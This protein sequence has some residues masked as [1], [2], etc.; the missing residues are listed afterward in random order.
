MKENKRVLITIVILL[1]IFLP[2]T[3]I[4]IVNNQSAREKDNDNENN[5]RELYKNGYLWFYD[6]KGMF[7][8]KYK[9]E[10]D[11]CYLSKGEIDDETYGIN[12]PK[13]GTDE[14]IKIIN[15]HY[16]FIDDNKQIKFYDITKGNT[17][18]TYLSAKNY[19]T[20]L[21]N[22]RIILKNAQ[23]K[24]GVI[25]FSE[26]IDAVLPFEYDFIGL[27]DNGENINTKSFV[28]LKD[29]K[30]KI[31][32]DTNES[33]SGEF[34]NP[35]VDFNSRYIVCYDKLRY[36]VFSRTG[37]A[38]F[39]DYA[40]QDYLIK[41]GYIG[42]VV[43]NNLMIYSDPNSEA[44]KNIYIGDTYETLDLNIKDTSMEIVVDN[45]VVETIELS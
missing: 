4:G 16:A 38:Y 12:Y 39:S 27:V 22:N 15:H 18:T 7:L 26:V 11:S 41:D 43:A 8:S 34:D 14:F 30:W 20:T 17:L 32:T 24:W 25:G 6:D 29:N 9:C 23:G 28:V 37:N 44:L 13:N 19:N 5:N 45:N 21:E 42:L 40:I 33:T 2:L 10:S 36:L 31:V 1:G 3:I 35:I